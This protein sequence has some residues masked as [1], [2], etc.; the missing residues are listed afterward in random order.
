MRTLILALLCSSA[1]ATPE[2]DLTT[3]LNRVQAWNAFSISQYAAIRNR[4]DSLYMNFSGLLLQA[5]EHIAA[6]EYELRSA[7]TTDAQ[8]IS[9]WQHEWTQSCS[10][11]APGPSVTIEGNAQ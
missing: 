11:P 1:H 7:R 10:A 9:A 8:H 6:L 5:N 3:S 2:A 4:S